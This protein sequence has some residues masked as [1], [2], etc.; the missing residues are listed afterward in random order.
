MIALGHDKYIWI[1]SMESIHLMDF[2]ME[3][4]AFTVQGQGHGLVT[5]F[6]ILYHGVREKIATVKLCIYALLCKIRQIPKLL[7]VANCLN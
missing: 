4:A 2:T 6:Y 3:I 5:S 7:P 1:A